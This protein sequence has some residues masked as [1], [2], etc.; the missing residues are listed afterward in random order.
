[1]TRSTSRLLTAAHR[2]S[3]EVLADTVKQKDEIIAG[4]VRQVILEL[5]LFKS[6][7]FM[8]VVFK[9]WGS[10]AIAQQRERLA[11]QQARINELEHLPG[12][13]TTTPL[14]LGS[15]PQG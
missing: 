15:L 14:P 3:E 11:A 6:G 8:L 2:R 9:F 10:L 13:L 1:M 5:V 7:V 12:L 4:T